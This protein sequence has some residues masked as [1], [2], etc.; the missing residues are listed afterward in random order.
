MYVFQGETITTDIGNLPVDITDIQ[1]IQIIFHTVTSTILCKSND[2]CKTD[3]KVITCDLTQDES[4]SLPCGPISRTIVILTRDGAR[5][6]RRDDDL[7]I[8]STAQRGV[9]T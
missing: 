8:V 4:L 7:I 2:D 6:E 1:T 9:I 5:F 3:G